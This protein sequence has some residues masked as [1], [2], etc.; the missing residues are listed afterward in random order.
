MIRAQ[1]AGMKRSPGTKSLCS[2]ARV[3][4]VE[5]GLPAGGR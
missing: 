3:D 1:T 5:R 4:R 2:A